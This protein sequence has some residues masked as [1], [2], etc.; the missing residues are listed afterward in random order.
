MRLGM[1]VAAGAITLLPRIASATVYNFQSTESSALSSS[2]S[3][4]FS[5]NT[6]AAV[7]NANG[8]GFN[9]ITITKN[10]TSISGNSVEATFTTSLGSGRLFFFTDTNTPTLPFYS[11]SGT[12]ISFDSG[13]FEIADGL[14]D[15]EGTLT[16]AA[17]PI[18][19][20]PEPATWAVLFAGVFTA[21]AGLQLSRARQGRKHP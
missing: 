20:V 9:N 13:T 3:F 10:G 12:D 17:V 8:T 11:G 15:G 16:I 18:S 7:I 4:S 19:A 14:T 6:A 5:L 1:I 21:G 2:T